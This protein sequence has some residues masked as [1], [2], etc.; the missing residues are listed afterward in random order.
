VFFIKQK[1]PWAFEKDQNMII[2][3]DIDS[4]M[5]ACFLHHFLNW[6]IKGFY[7][8]Y[9]KLFIEEGFDNWKECI[10]VDLDIS[11]NEIK[12]IGHHILQINENDKIEEIGHK[13]SLNPNLI[14]GI[15][16]KNFAVKYPL[17]T[18]HFLMW[19]HNKKIEIN[20][21][22]KN[23]SWVPDSSWINCQNFR[24]NVSNWIEFLKLDN[25]KQTFEQTD[26][27]EF[28]KIMQEKIY[29][30]IEKTGFEKGKGQVKSKHLSLKGYQCQFDDPINEKD[31]INKLIEL[32]CNIF[33]WN[34]PQ[35]PKDYQILEGKRTSH[36]IPYECYKNGLMDFIKDKNMFSYVIPNYRM[37][38]YTIF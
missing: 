17:G 20:N 37:I 16:M 33:E 34:K 14:R 24:T 21:E 9:S 5:S 36:S 8:G 18:I 27:Q 26:K 22:I 6:K 29:P 30:E 4:I 13:N 19:L 2:G 10:F 38:N 12:S 1:F 11:Q 3:D 28:E 7:V 32:I 15:T 31:K 35:L 23:I 25:L